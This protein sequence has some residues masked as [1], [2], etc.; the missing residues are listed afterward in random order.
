MGYYQIAQTDLLIQ[1]Q[2][3]KQLIQQQLPDNL[4]LGKSNC[5]QLDDN[6]RYIDTH[7]QPSQDLAITNHVQQQDTQ[8]V[9]TLGIQ[10]Q[11]R[12]VEK[13]GLE[14]CFEQGYATISCFNA[15]VGERQYQANKVLRQLRLLLNRKWLERYLGEE[16]ADLFLNKDTTQI[17][18]HQP[19]APQSLLLAQQLLTPI[20]AN[21]LQ[22]LL[23]H[24]HAMSIL[25]N[26]LQGLCCYKTGGVADHRDKQAIE[27]VNEA[28]DILMRD[29]K[30]PPSVDCLAKQVGINSNKLKKLFHQY[31][32]TTPYGLLLDIRMQKAMQLLQT[33]HYQVAVVADLV[34]YQHA[35]NF[36]SAFVKYFGQSPKEFC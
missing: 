20:D 14:L 33:T 15:S 36:S 29:F 25:S 4:G 35:S 13:N 16:Q 18:S 7:Y 34:G 1:S 12:F 22:A 30:T 5:F 21:P 11:S 2:A 8:I 17:L 32:E 27:V 6:L 9:L 26:E 23:R 19:I 31:F 3:D 28:R 24:T 10:G